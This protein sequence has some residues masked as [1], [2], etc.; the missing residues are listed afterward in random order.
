MVAPGHAEWS[1]GGAEGEATTTL[2]HREQRRP[3]SFRSAS[4]CLSFCLPFCHPRCN[5]RKALSIPLPKE[6]HHVICRSAGTE[7]DTHCQTFLLLLHF[8]FPTDSPANGQ[9]HLPH[10]TIR[11]Q[12]SS[13]A[14]RRAPHSHPPEPR[15]PTPAAPAAEKMQTDSI[16]DGVRT[17]LLQRL[18]DLQCT[19]VRIGTKGTR[20]ESGSASTHQPMGLGVD[21]REEPNSAG[22]RLSTAITPKKGRRNL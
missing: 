6:G 22:D 17:R 10:P 13:C 3:L 7:N 18:E 1:Q 19:D 20:Q 15:V 9:L 14:S 16:K 4:F 2:V 8:P 11:T 21:I 12:Q 5:Q